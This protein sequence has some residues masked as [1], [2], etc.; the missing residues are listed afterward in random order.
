MKLGV[1]E[2]SVR[3]IFRY[4]AERWHILQQWGA[5]SN[6]AALAES[7]RRGAWFKV[8]GS[9]VSIAS[10]TGGRQGCILGAFTFNCVY[11]IAL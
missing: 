10:S 3:W 7:L 5:G 2:Q 8:N 11:S 9:Q 1:S 4:L 6:A